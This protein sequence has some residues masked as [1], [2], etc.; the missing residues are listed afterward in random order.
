MNTRPG[1]RTMAAS[2]WN[3]VGV[4]STGRPPTA[5]RMG[6]VDL[7][8][9]DPEHLGAAGPAASVRRSTARTLATS[10]LGLNGLT[11]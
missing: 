11:T 1:S 5:T 7:D 10:S 2:S 3:S 6:Q 8:V 9:G 4:S